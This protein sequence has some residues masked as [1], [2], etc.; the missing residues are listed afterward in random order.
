MI[1][2]DGSACL[3]DMCLS[4]YSE[5]RPGLKSARWTA[6]EL[7]KVI[8]EGLGEEDDNDDDEYTYTA[9]ENRH[10]HTKLHAASDIWSLGALILEALTGTVPYAHISDSTTVVT[11]VLAGER[12]VLPLRQEVVR[13]GLDDELW[14]L[15]CQCWESD[16]GRRPGLRRVR[17]VVGRLAK[18]WVGGY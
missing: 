11:A 12:P 9:N 6:T 8:A 1:Q 10:P 13:Y 18:A 17:D 16:P 2:D 3:A 14:R 4:S 7:L 15:L 5:A